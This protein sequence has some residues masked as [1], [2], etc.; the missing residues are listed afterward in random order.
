MPLTKQ[1]LLVENNT[2]FPN[3]TIGYITPA[4]LRE[5][6]ADMIDA[7]Q[8]T[9]SM[10]E[11]AVLSGGN[12][13]TGN[14]TIVGNLN[15]NGV[16]SASV[17]YV[18]TETAS[19]IY[20][21]GSNQF[22]DELIDVQTLSGSVKVQGSLT[23]NGVPVLTGSVSVDTGSLV[24]TASF[25][26]Y[27]AS[28]NAEISALEA[29]T[30]S[31]NTSISNLNTFTQSANISIS[32]LN[33]FTQSQ[34]A[35]N[36]QFA[37]TGSN[38]FTG[39]QVI[40]R[41]SKLYT[42]G[43]YWTDVTAGF[44]NLEIIN[45]GGGNLD[46][47]SLNGGKVRFVSSS[48]NFLNSP[49]SSSNE[50]S[51]SANIYAAN[52][53]GS[54][55]PSGLLSSSV[56]NFTDYSASVDSRINNITGSS[57][58]TGS[59]ATTGS[60]TF[61]GNQTI[62]TAGN[63]QLTLI[64]QPGFQTNV[65]FQSENS[66]FQA[67]GDFRINNNGQFG[68]SGSIKML[69]KDNF[70]E[71]AAS[72]GFRMGVSNAT[73][74]G[75]EGGFVTINV[76]S[77]SEQ[78]QLTGSLVVSNTL[79]A[80][81]AEGYVW[82]G[83]AGNISTLVATSSFGGTVPAGVYATLGTN[84]FTG[85]QTIQNASLT[86][87][88]TGSLFFNLNGATQN[89]ILFNSPSNQFT[90]YGSFV[91][92]NNGNA[93]GSGSLSF[94]AVSSSVTFASRDGLYI[95]RATPEAGALGNGG[96]KVNTTSGS[97]VLAPSGFNNRDIDLLHLSSSS[98]TNNLNLIFKNNNTAA[99]TI[100]SGS[101]NIFS[102]QAAPTAGFKRYM[103]GG[104][105]A[106]AANGAA[107]PQISGSMAW[108]PTI[109][110]NIFAVTATPL[111]WRGPVSA[112][113]STINNNVF[114]GGQVLLGSNAANNFEKATNATTINANVINGN[115]IAVAYKTPLSS[116]VSIGNNNISGQVTLAMDSSSINFSGN[117]VQ[118]Q[119]AV[120]NS[121]FPS[122]INTAAS[123]G[124]SAGL[125]IGTNAIYA[126]GS[127][128]TFTGPRAIG[129]GI[130][131]IG[132]QN[133]I[134]ASLNGDNS[135]VACTNLIGQGLV[136]LGT[137]TRQNANLM[138]DYGTVFVG[139]FNDFSGNKGG[140]AETVFAVGTGTSGSAGITRKTG[141]LID[142]GSNTF[143]EG[144]LNVS[145]ST[146]LSGSLYIQSGSTLPA[147]TGS[148]VLTWNQL[149]GQVAQSPLANVLANTFSL[150]VFTSTIT[151]SGSAA[152][153]QSMTFNNTEESSGVTLSNDSRLNVAT[154]GYYNIQF[155]AQLLADTGA[156][157]VWIW[158]KKNGT[159]VPNTGTRVTLANNEEIVAAWNFVVNATAGDY[160]EL[161]WQSADGH[162][163]LLT[164]PASG[165]YPVIPS[166][167]VTVTQ[168]R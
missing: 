90:S 30:A 66:N 40:D 32:A 94:V 1:A 154:S 108:S 6:N 41:A 105:I 77:G 20:S 163:E 104:N 85:S 150:G 120:N 165:N 73:G 131:M 132:S 80:S 3:N 48:V 98:N 125:F 5:F 128:A 106:I 161:V 152:V 79:T 15:V 68:G 111:Q 19:V 56:T 117:S 17:L 29:N 110:S 140:T 112:S 87:T 51:T 42:N 61:T 144:T 122:T 43:I 99:D 130:S 124:V 126:S 71:F 67:Y 23:V 21:S 145:G 64:A 109:S 155:S 113:A 142:S 100:I 7:M 33:A 57:I 141:F 138:S 12:T 136:A 34:A 37:T 121:Y 31:V 107:V 129:N 89:N 146:T 156:D 91:F 28:T 78:L 166:V 47:A 53:T 133:V 14:Q 62:S 72:Q 158:L 97:L 49:I 159:N 58:N 60:N 38:T 75:I 143:I 118:G 157:D 36:G 2:N 103:T 54:T 149:T 70:M 39:N 84:T 9:Q 18:Q 92:N 27:T 55:L 162:A 16:I 95:T 93:G 45:Q 119:L 82:A 164:E 50:I 83:G 168:V 116:S 148:S 22:G 127:N 4:L 8:L 101:N 44:N 69:V 102:N 88:N 13:F 134:S 115:L 24:T 160:Y 74:N 137:N 167:I 153:S 35:L 10:S 96:V 26:A 59:F 151:Q 135:N 65:E 25:N 123:L 81:L 46:L 76:P 63:S 147:A 11:Y 86:V 114:A 139:R 52:L